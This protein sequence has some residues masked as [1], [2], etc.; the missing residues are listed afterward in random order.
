[1]ND[2]Q[3]MKYLYNAVRYN[4]SHPHMEIRPSILMKKLLRKKRK[5]H[6]REVKSRS[7]GSQTAIK[8]LQ[9]RIDKILDGDMA[10]DFMRIVDCMLDVHGD[11]QSEHVSFL[12]KSSQQR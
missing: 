12:C 6:R 8:R 11:V 10:V 7:I 4:R 2:S 3:H 9:C 5:L 1:M